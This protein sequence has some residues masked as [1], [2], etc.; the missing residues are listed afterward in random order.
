M[1]QAAHVT[2]R[3]ADSDQTQSELA[4]MLQMLVD[5][6]VMASLPTPRITEEEYL[7]V[8]RAAEIK[9]EFVDGWIFAMSVGRSLTRSSH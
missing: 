8:E 6:G 3:L 4:V 7:Q 9:S 5:N 2:A 1:A